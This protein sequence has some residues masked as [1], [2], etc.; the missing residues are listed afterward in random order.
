[1]RDVKKFVNRWTN[2]GYE[3]GEAQT[4]WL[5]LL[6]DVFAVDEPENFINF[7]VPIPQGFIDAFLPD[8]NTLIEQKSSSVNLDDPEIFLQAKRYND[9]L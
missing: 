4:F 5:N 2:H 3:K 7:E 1:M 9:A 8:T 6:R